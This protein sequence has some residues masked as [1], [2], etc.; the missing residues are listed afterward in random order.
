MSEY[1]Y[2]LF[3]ADNTLFDFDKCETEAFKLAIA[4]SGVEF[5]DE[6]YATYHVINER[7]WKLLEQ[8]GIE[9]ATLKTERYRLLFEKYGIERDI[10]RDVAKDY[11]HLLGDQI[12]EIDGVYEL[13]MR[14]GKRFDIYVITNGL[15]SVQE[16]R[17]SKS[18]ITCLVKDVFISENVGY[19]KPDKKYFDHVLSVVGDPDISKY[20]VVGDSLSSDIDGAIN[21]G[22][23]CCW[24][25]RNSSDRCGRTPTYEISDITQIEAI[26]Q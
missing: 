22:F 11:E 9:R 12:F 13:L 15:T 25:N 23:D 8:G 1:K 10:Y 5:S 16:S 3:D 6:L 26:L 24:Y 7:L 4:K 14:L 18:R 21:Y 19:A 17:F 20:I 2:I